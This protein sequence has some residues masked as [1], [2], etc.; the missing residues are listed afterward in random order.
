MCVCDSMHKGT[1]RKKELNEK[2]ESE[3]EVNISYMLHLFLKK[4]FNGDLNLLIE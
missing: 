4:E 1:Q 2:S 3:I